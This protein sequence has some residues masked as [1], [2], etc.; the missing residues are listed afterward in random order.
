MSWLSVGLGLVRLK[1][2]GKL[3]AA[4]GRARA[5]AA[6]PRVQASPARAGSLLDLARDVA[7]DLTLED[8]RPRRFG[9]L[10][11]CLIEKLAGQPGLDGACERL[12]EARL[13][14][15][16]QRPRLREG[17]EGPEGE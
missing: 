17:S 12:A 14:D 1:T 16:Q 15:T 3:H 5:H 6:W 9:Q 4:S 2:C 10:G 8:L 13:V 11:R 7:P